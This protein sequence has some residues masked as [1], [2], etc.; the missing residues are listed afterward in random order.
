MWQVLIEPN[1]V[2]LFRDG[3]PFAAGEDHRA[4]SLFPPMP[5]TMQGVVRSKVLFDSGVGLR[6]YA[7][8][9]PSA[10]A[11]IQQIGTPSGN[12]GQL[13]LHG[14]FVAKRNDEGSIIRYFPLP[15]D[16]VNVGDHYRLVKPL[17]EHPFRSNHP[18]GLCLLWASTEGPLKEARGWLAEDAFRKYLAGQTDLHV[19]PESD[20]LVREPRFGIALDYT[21]RRPHE[22]LLY[23]MEFLRLKDGVGFL[24]EVDGI[25]PFQPQKGFVQIGGEARA[26]QYEVLPEPLPPLPTVSA[27]TQRVRIILLT[28][29]WFADGCQP[30]GANWATFFNGGGQIRLVTAALARAQTIGG[31][32]VDDQRRQDNFQKTMRR[33]APAGSVFFFESDGPVTVGQ[34]P[35]TETPDGEG[36]FGQIGFGSIA[37]TS[38][39]YV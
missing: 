30:A 27:S 33:F 14:P 15:A 28:P 32:F 37:M 17:S 18:A 24:L 13:R 22:G 4:R 26:A 34:H 36:N 9:A 7:H 3:K 35:L 12:Y 39:D 2:L 20:L 10:Q 16:V 6:D 23:Q 19:T 8:G 5:F 38:W 11:L 31:A 1:D 25:A 29:A 21:S